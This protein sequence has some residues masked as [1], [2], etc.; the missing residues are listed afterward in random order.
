MEAYVRDEELQMM[1][2][3]QYTNK[4]VGSQDYLGYKI[5]LRIL[6]ISCEN[7]IQIS[8]RE[9][10]ISGQESMSRFLSD[11]L[12]SLKKILIHMIASKLINKFHIIDFFSC[13]VSNHIWID[14]NF[15]FFSFVL[16]NLLYLWFVLS[17]FRVFFSL[18]MWL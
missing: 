7:K 12:N 3:F 17:C 8:M 13:V 15:L 14:N 6:F 1:A 11:F 4:M 16:L 10:N 5:K 2:L 18:M 9:E